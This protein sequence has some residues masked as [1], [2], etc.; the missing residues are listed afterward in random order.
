M[1]KYATRNSVPTAGTLVRLIG[2]RL[3][4]PMHTRCEDNDEP[5]LSL[6]KR[7]LPSHS[8]CFKGRLHLLRLRIS[9]IPILLILAG[10]VSCDRNLDS[11]DYAPR[12]NGDWKV[13][14]P[15][16]QG[17]DPK[18]VAQLYSNASEVQTL[19]SLLVVKNGF[20]IAERYYRGGAVDQ[21]ERLQS[22][23]KSYTSAL[24]GIALEQGCLSSVDQKMTRIQQ[25]DLPSS[26]YRCRTGCRQ[27]SQIL[28][29]GAPVL[30]AERR[31][32]RPPLQSGMGTRGTANRP[33]A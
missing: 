30:T 13:S 12:S 24:V 28:C 2:I 21:K 14:T 8:S 17:L 18:L 29:R 19:R 33:C 5:Q 26:G 27:G 23:T 4:Y 6:P 32:G 10:C 7:V 1:P 20:L 31:S 9:A 15:A 3:E 22:V 11:I 16:E 25:S